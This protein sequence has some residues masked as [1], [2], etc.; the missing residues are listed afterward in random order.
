MQQQFAR[1]LK[2]LNLRQETPSRHALERIVRSH[3]AL[4]PFENLSKLLAVRT[5]GAR[6][7]PDLSGFLDGVE[8]FHLG[9]TCY[10]VNYHL[11]QLLHFL[12]YEVKLC[13]ADMSKPDV[14][15]VNLVTV[16]NREFLVDAGYAAPFWV[17]LPRDLPADFTITLG[18]D[19]YVLTPREPDGRSRL[20]LYRS[21]AARHGYCINPRPREMSEFAGVVERS[22]RPESTFMRALL[23]T[24]FAEESSLVLHNMTLLEHRGPSVKGTTFQTR[25]ELFAAVETMFGIPR[26]F[27]HRALEGIDL[28][29]DPWG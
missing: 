10:A 3:L 15:L 8:R 19:A 5:T 27:T 11:H 23:I 14:H 13:G 29:A 12:G 28:A 20:T 25:E 17:P 26:D 7:I 22:Y 24:R 16:D 1:Y 2:L 9:G 18:D 21:G 6:S 4:I